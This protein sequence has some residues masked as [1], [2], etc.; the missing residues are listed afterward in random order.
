MLEGAGDQRIERTSLL[1]RKCVDS[2]AVSI[3]YGVTVVQIVPKI[4]GK[5]SICANS[6]YQALSFATHHELGTRLRTKENTLP[7]PSH[8]DNILPH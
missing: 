6:G 8:K 1:V 5:L 3:R 2:V 4:S 7:L